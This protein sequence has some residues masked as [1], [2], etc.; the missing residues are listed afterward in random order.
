MSALARVDSVEMVSST[1]RV[2][3]CKDSFHTPNILKEVHVKF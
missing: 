1:A 3:H 2:S